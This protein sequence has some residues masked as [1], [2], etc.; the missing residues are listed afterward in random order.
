VILHF[1]PEFWRKGNMRSDYSFASVVVEH[2][3]LGGMGQL[4][5]CGYLGTVSAAVDHK[6]GVGPGDPMSGP[7]VSNNPSGGDLTSVI[8][9]NFNGHS[10]EQVVEEHTVSNVTP[11]R[12]EEFMNM[13]V[14]KGVESL[15]GS[16]AFWSQS[17]SF[18]LSRGTKAEITIKG[19]IS[20]ESLA[21]LKAHI[22]L[23]IQAL[24]D[25]FE[26]ET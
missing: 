9:R 5:S 19:E 7:Q 14:S 15:P 21:R 13:A 6:G 17:Y 11:G 24:S 8:Q 23:T 22:E 10:T 16:P 12:L 25:D 1:S 4:G 18:P 20:K 2:Q 26:P 3:A